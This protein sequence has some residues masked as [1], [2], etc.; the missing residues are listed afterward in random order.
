MTI[1]EIQAFVNEGE[2]QH[3]EFKK[4]VAHPEKIV[5]EIVAFANTEGGRLLIGVDDNGIIS[6]VKFAEEDKFVL[7]KAIVDFCRPR[8]RFKSEII[9]LSEKKSIINYTIYESKKKPHY[10]VEN[11]RG[12]AYVRVKDRSI[13]ASKEVREILRRSRRN[14]DI[15]FHYGDK[16]KILMEYLAV[17]HSINIKKFAEIAGVSRYMAS[18]TLV[19]LVLAN[20]LKLIPQEK[21]DVY[22]INEKY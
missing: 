7:E 17:H 16:E 13:Q 2:N 22:V 12:R 5:R 20:V 6:G 10:V 8:V 1:R 19:L 4:K 11:K 18:K 3:L 9:K 15:K 21:E 14:K